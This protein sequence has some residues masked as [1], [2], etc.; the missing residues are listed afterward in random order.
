MRFVW[1]ASSASVCMAVL[2][3]AAAAQRVFVISDRNA[4]LTF[5]CRILGVSSIEGHFAK[6]G[7]LVVIDDDKPGEARTA[8]KI[9]ADSLQVEDAE[10]QDELLGADFFNATIF[11]LAEFN[12]Y[13]ARLNQPGLLE[14]QGRLTLRGI[15]K[16]VTL[17]V[18]YKLPANPKEHTAQIHAE[19][20]IDRTAFGMTAYELFLSDT[21]TITV[22]GTVEMSFAP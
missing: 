14:V 15:T 2:C 13:S 5:E 12:S 18:A 21:V 9:R 11:P 1:L 3:T 7:A 20:K 10:R 17:Q 19:A 8:V 6:F 16:P 22:S 4:S